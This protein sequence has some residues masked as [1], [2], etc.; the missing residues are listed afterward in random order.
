MS[1]TNL[2][3]T[4]S[5]RERALKEL[6]AA[7]EISTSHKTRAMAEYFFFGGP[8]EENDPRYHHVRRVNLMVDMEDR[9]N[10]AIRILE[11]E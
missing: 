2:T 5:R 6:R 8:L 11:G 4:R 10:Q 3:E 7:A 1:V 9:I